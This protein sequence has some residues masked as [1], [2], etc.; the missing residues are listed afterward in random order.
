M[1]VKTSTRKRVNGR[2][3]VSKQKKLI[4]VDRAVSTL[5][6]TSSNTLSKF[7]QSYQAVAIFMFSFSILTILSI[8]SKGG[9]VGEV[10]FNV[11][12]LAFGYGVF[13]LPVFF[14]YG[15]VI[16]TRDRDEVKPQKVLMGTI[17]VQIISS[18]LFHSLIHIEPL[19]LSSGSN[20]LMKS[21]GYFSALYVYPLFN[22]SLI[23]I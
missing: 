14:I 20:V 12:Q 1:A 17:Y 6:S 21:G 4:N 18:G 22:L 15:S 16:L 10:V 7:V 9:P 8:F 19:S 23:H 5:K 3:R 11:L 2:K 13:A